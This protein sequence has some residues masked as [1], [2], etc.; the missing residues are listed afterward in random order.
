MPFNYHV[1]DIDLTL[2]ERPKNRDKRT[3][4][5]VKNAWINFTHIDNEGVIWVDTQRMADILRT[6]AA[7]ARYIIGNLREE[8]IKKYGQKVFI[9]GYRLNGL[10][11]EHIQKEKLGKRKDYLLY[12][13]CIYKRIRDCQAVEILRIKYIDNI[14][15]ERKKLK[16][17]RIKKYSIKVDELTGMKLK[18]KTAEFSHIRSA[19]LFKFLALEIENGLIVNKETHSIITVEGI[20]DES[21]LLEL[22]KKRSWN[23]DWY[24]KFKSY[25]RLG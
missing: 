25:F 8:D 16:K 21:E 14:A 9:R 24:G 15:E 1:A 6:T 10:L 4:S 18:N 22:C 20:C 7:K 3:C 5:R 12:S 17:L 23:T 11:D 2:P 13:E 19:S